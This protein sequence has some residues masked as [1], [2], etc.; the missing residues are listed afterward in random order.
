MNEE[1]FYCAVGT[2]TS[3][4]IQVKLILSGNVM[5]EAASRR[6][7]KAEPRVPSQFNA[8]D[9]CS[10]R[11]GTGIGLIPS[12]S[13]FPC[14]YDSRITLFSFTSTRC[15]YLRTNRIGNAPKAEW[16][17]GYR[18]ALDRKVLNVLNWFKKNYGKF[19][20]D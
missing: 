2:E 1:Y 4:M 19:R 10:R 5:A 14:Q 3:H 11:R 8:C 16:S 18:G 13:V 7:P 15:P 17:V 12:I 6:P 9:I 20:R